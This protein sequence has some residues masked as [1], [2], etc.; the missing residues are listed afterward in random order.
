MSRPTSAI[1]DLQALREN[2]SLAQKLAPNAKSMPMVKANAYGHGMLEVATALADSAPAFGVAC[3]EEALALRKANIKQP[4][5]LLEGP[6]SADEIG[7]AEQYG[8]WLMLENHNQLQA[9]LSAQLST[10][11]TVWIKL[12]TG[13]HRLGFQPENASYVYKQLSES[14]N[15]AEDIV[16]ATHFAFADNLDNDFTRQQLCNFEVALN[17]ID[18][19]NLLKSLANSA[20]ILDWPEVKDDWQR[21][22]YMLYGASPFSEPQE[23]AEQ[24]KQVMHFQSAVISIRTIATGESVGYTANWTAERPSTI[25]TIAVGYGDGYPRHAPNGTPVLINGVKCPL[26]GKVSMD[27]ITVDI[28]DLN[29]EVEIGA[30]ATLWGPQL[31]VTEVAEYCGTIGYEL[32]TR[33]PARVPRIYINAK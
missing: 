3:I 8:F 6:H 24:L 30:D 22:G 7:I 29:D 4:I 14:P 23:N 17:D 26:V 15:V 28:T 5:L 2:F 33:M 18:Q 21:P 10:A 20:A 19:P 11:I 25:A 1:I 32:L 27:M 16:L 31:S 12:D 9:V 13:M